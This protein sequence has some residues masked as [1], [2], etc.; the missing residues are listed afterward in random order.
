ML[1]SVFVKSSEFGSF[2]PLAHETVI[3]VLPYIDQAQVDR[4]EPILRLR[5]EQDGLLVLVD[6][7]ERMG[8]IK[9]ANFVY[10]RTRSPYF[11]YLAQDAYPGMYWLREGV[12]LLERT[13]AGLL[14]FN[15][16]R[17]FGTLAAFGLVRRDWVNRLYHNMLFYPGYHSQYGDTEISA[18]AYAT[19]QLVFNP[20]ALLVEVDWEKHT[21]ANNAED[22]ALYKTRLETGFDGRIPADA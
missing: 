22:D 1:E 18:I 19:H 16:G 15:E 9:V 10:A 6:D 14:A 4:A 13:G 20:N 12:Q 7:D 2:E 11:G 17:F 21:K 3:M 8:F 5:A